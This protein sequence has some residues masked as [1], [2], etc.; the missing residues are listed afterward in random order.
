M[1]EGNAEA[2]WAKVFEE[3]VRIVHGSPDSL[4]VDVVYFLDGETELPPFKICQDFCAI[5]TKQNEN[6]NL[7]IVEDGIVVQCFK[8]LP[9]EGNNSLLMTWKFHKQIPDDILLPILRRVE[10]NVILKVVR[11]IRS[12]LTRVTRTRYRTQVKALLKKND[13]VSRTEGL[14]QLS[15][16]TLLL[17]DKTISMEDIKSLAFQMGQ[18]A[19]LLEGVELYSKGT[20]GERYPTL[21]PF[22]QRNLAETIDNI[23]KLDTFRDRFV[24]LL[25][26]IK[27]KT[28]GELNLL[29]CWPDRVHYEGTI[30]N[31]APGKEKCIL[32]PPPVSVVEPV[33]YSYLDQHGKL[34]WSLKDSL[35]ISVELDQKLGYDPATFWGAWE[36]VASGPKKF[37][38]IKLLSLRS[39]K[40]NKV[41]KDHGS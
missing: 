34:A 1:L 25:C 3:A 22:L 18:T 21:Q 16:E 31:V 28:L 11:C 24:D 17:K 39:A 33:A 8:G 5:G 7:M 2:R 37:K 23:K 4:D 36:V 15:F 27:L 10:R 19:A 29:V 9:D 32:Y 35:N 30:L 38:A 12:V 6:R 41:A 14:K 20:V 40:S 26:G 13:L